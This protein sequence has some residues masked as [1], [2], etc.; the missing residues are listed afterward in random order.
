MMDFSEK[1][2]SEPDV[3]CV[4][5][6]ENQYAPFEAAIRTLGVENYFT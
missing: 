6:G 1:D 3:Y 5:V 2:A 4:H